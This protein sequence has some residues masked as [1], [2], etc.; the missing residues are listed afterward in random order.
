LLDRLGSSNLD[1]VDRAVA[2]IFEQAAETSSADVLYAAARACEDKLLDP[3]RALA[4]YDRITRD[5]GDARVSIAAG[6]RAQAL[7]ALVGS[8]NETQAQAAELAR[9]IARADAEPPDAVIRRAERLAD[10][11]WPGAPAAALWL[12][13]WLRRSG[14]LAEA[15]AHYAVVVT[16]WPAL[17]EAAAALRGGAGCALEAHDWSLAETLADRL[18]AAEPGSGAKLERDELVAAAERGRRR[19]RWYG[20]AK[21]ALALAVA[22]LLGSLIEAVLRSPRGSRVSALRPPFEIVFL[23][24]VAAVLIGVAFTAHRL[25]APAVA[26]ICLGGLALAWLSGATLEQL[27]ARGRSHGLRSLVHVAACL[28]GVAALSYVAVTRDGLLDAVI[29]TVQFGPEP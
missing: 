14:R 22:A 16:R 29:E 13:D 12:A 6:R 21:L 18:A 20:L 26:T 4:I 1:D 25:I 7:R 17:P 27:R 5:H 23:G 10:A 2:A 3:A 28:A 9:L 19:D 8:H 24:P 15:A 11:A